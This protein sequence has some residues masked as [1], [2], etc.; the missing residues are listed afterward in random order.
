MSGGSSKQSSA[1]TQKTFSTSSSGVNTGEVL[2]AESIQIQ[3]DFDENVLQAFQGLTELLGNTVQG[4]GELATKSLDQ[5]SQRL[6]TQEQPSLAAFTSVIPLL[7]LTA[8]AII[9][10]SLRK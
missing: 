9:I 2:T 7:M 1:Q 8:G 3:S 4:A 10:F 5:V 6:E